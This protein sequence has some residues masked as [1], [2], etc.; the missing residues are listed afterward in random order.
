MNRATPVQP[1]IQPLTTHGVARFGRLA[2]SFAV[3][4]ALALLAC[5]YFALTAAGGIISTND[6]S[7]YALT[8]ALAVDG[9]ARID[10]YVSY[11]AIQPPQGDADDRRLPRCQFPRRAFLLRSPPRHG[12]PGGAVLLAR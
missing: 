6:G 11:G 2:R 8:K 7:H 5:L 3:T 12:V 10:P 4:L 9:S 1:T